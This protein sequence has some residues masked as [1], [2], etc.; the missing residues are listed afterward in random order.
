M[1]NPGHASSDRYFRQL[2]PHSEAVIRE[3]YSAGALPAAEDGKLV[4][5]DSTQIS[6]L[7]GAE[8]HRLVVETSAKTTLEIGLA[9]GF[10]TAWIL[11]AL[12]RNRGASH[13]AIDPFQVDHWGGVGL[14]TVKR[15]NCV[16]RFE[17]IQER[18]D[19]ALATMAKER[20]VFDF[21]Y[22]DGNHRFDDVLV[23][24]YLADQVLRLGG[25][26]LFDDIWM[27]SVQS[28]CS[29]V[30]RNRSY[31]R[32]PSTAGN[33]SVFRKLQ[34]DVRNWQHFVPFNG[35]PSNPIHRLT[36]RLKRVFQ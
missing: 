23:D 36:R 19:F 18:S 27:P 29:F 32:V 14:Q 7:Q 1:R 10:S 8:L 13:I 24:F 22:I 2:L 25:L 12:S 28:A 9:Y 17:W 33:V 31:E 26:I 4:K 16:D 35:S 30:E 6:P 21:I 5:L 11:D 3:M 20:K 15:L 34:N